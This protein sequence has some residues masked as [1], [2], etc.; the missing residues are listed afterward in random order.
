MPKSALLA[1]PFLPVF[2]AKLAT[3]CPVLG[4]FDPPIGSTL[5]PE[6]AAK[7]AI[8]VTLGSLTTDAAVM[9]RLPG[10]GLICCYGSG[11]E[12]VDLA[13]AKRRG[14]HVAHSRGANA[15]AVAEQAMALLLAACRRTV[16]ADRVVRITGWRR[17]PGGGLPP[18][19]GLDGRRLGI[20]GLGAIGSRI[21]VCAAP[22]GPEIGYHNRAPR[23]DVPYRYFPTLQ[24][25]ADWAD[26]LMVAARADA[27]NRRA[28]SREVMQALGPHGIVVNISRGSILDEPAL[29]DLLQKGELG[30]AGLDVFENEPNVP[31]ALKQLPQAV[32][33]PHIGGSTIGAQAAMQ[34][35]VLANVTAF[36][37]GDR[38]PTPVPEMMTA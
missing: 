38:P 36:L 26:I 34:D 32:L 11:Y 28:V 16:E 2:R 35:M 6:Q 9:Q 1:Y 30:A 23:P 18:A 14:I 15:A 5:P 12:G 37:R 27:G 13:E 29:I 31:E 24:A 7:V 8:L 33:T 21:A 20:F 17:G 4:P 3:V 10:L 22:F 25:L 19:R